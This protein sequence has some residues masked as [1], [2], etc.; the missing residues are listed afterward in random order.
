M[1]NNLLDHVKYTN[2]EWNN[3]EYFLK[4]IK[5][6]NA[7]NISSIVDLGANVGEVSNILYENIK[8]IEN[9]YLFEPQ[10]DNYNFIISKFKDNNKFKIFNYGIYY[11]SEKINLYKSKDNVGGHSIHELENSVIENAN[12]DKLENFNIN[13]IDFI[14]IDVE[15]SEYNIIEN[16]NFLKTI[17]YIDLEIHPLG[18]KE[19]NYFDKL[20]R[21]NYMIN[22]YFKKYLNDYEVLADWECHFFLVKNNFK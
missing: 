15:G 7:K 3:E 5:Y 9:F 10:I 18:L 11:S 2:R 20:E 19:V 1:P 13:N 16:S 8:S 14:K 22:K 21:K 4:I 17:P 12:F 6:L